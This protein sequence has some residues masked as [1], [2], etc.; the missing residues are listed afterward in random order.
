M[1]QQNTYHTSS[2]VS[3]SVLRIS[4]SFSF[5]RLFNVLFSMIKPFL[6]DRVRDNILFHGQENNDIY[7]VC[8]IFFYR[9]DLQSLHAEVSPELLPADL[10]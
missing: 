3:S 9:D 1:V 2:K 5:T 10:R 6:D 4:F 7:D 8:L